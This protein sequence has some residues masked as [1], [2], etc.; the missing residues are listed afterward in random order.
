MPLALHALRKAAR[1][2]GGDERL[3]AMLDVAPDEFARWKKGAEPVPQDVLLMVLDFLADMET[4]SKSFIL[5][6]GRV[7]EHRGRGQ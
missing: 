6:S 3:H 4:S 7:D 1:I 5:L 2:L